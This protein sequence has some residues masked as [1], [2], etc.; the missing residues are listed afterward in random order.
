MSESFT[1]TNR[2]IMEDLSAPG[3]R[4]M[5][6]PR[7]QS[8]PTVRTAPP[9]PRQTLLQ[10]TSSPTLLSLAPLSDRRQPLTPPRQ[11][12]LQATP[13]PTS[14][15]LA[16]LSDQRQPLAP[17]RQASFQAKPLPTIPS[18]AQLSDQRPP[19]ASSAAR[20][21]TLTM[22]AP[23][24][25]TPTPDSHFGH[26]PASTGLVV[27][28]SG[29][30]LPGLNTASSA[31]LY[32]SD[33]GLHSAGEHKHDAITIENMP[34][35]GRL[36]S[37]VGVNCSKI[38]QAICDD[39][40]STG[41]SIR[42]AGA[43]KPRSLGHASHGRSGETLDASERG[44]PSATNSKRDAL[45][46]LQKLSMLGIQLTRKYSMYD[47]YED[48]VYELDAHNRNREV[49]DAVAFMKSGLRMGFTGIEF[50]NTYAGSPLMLNNL[51]QDLCRDL[52]M[53][54]NVLEKIYA[55]YW[56]NRQSEPL[57]ELG[58]LL[59]SSIFMQHFK[60]KMTTSVIR[61]MHRRPTMNPCTSE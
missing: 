42:I 47:S 58:L 12:S 17:P 22:K 55:K 40:S 43:G 14:L 7:K 27:P 46:A 31:L 23:P 44:P 45:I 52:T 48:I 20:G 41:S 38:E 33:L 26:T 28:C 21:A 2:M 59:C 36:P 19:L 35:W 37:P 56:R 13:L 24:S 34:P 15:S 53:Y 25:P 54:N 32:T 39:E 1:I 29:P 51:T 50:T 60:N 10:G 5:G 11:V 18:L 30:G 4:S 57:A 6:R 16:Q 61:P 3:K 49:A 9:P 8:P